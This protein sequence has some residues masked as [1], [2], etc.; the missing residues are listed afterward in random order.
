MVVAATA[1]ITVVV[2]IV[3]AL[4]PLA[5]GVE[6]GVVVVAFRVAVVWVVA[7]VVAAVARFVPL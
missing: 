5:F 3:A 6:V 4:E 7:V 2:G 1:G